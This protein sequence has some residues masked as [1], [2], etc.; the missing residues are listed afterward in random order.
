VP[1]ITLY[2]VLALGFMMVMYAL[3]RRGRIFILAFALGCLLSARPRTAIAS[4]T[5]TTAPTWRAVCLTA[6]PMAKREAGIAWVER[7][8]MDFAEGSGEVAPAEFVVMNRVLCCYPDMPKLAAAAAAAAAAQAR[9]ALVLSFPSN[10][11]WTRLGMT[12]VNFGSASSGCNSRSSTIR[13][14]PSWPRSSA[15][16]SPRGSTS[17]D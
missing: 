13:R 14:R 9:R 8:V 11:W 2:G 12:V 17:G 10:H 4:A 1:L 16:G 15:T 5:P 7:K 3:E 6:P